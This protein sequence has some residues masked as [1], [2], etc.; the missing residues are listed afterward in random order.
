MVAAAA[1]PEASRDYL[2]CSTVAV[3]VIIKSQ[4]LYCVWIE[5]VL[6]AEV[7]LTQKANLH[8]RSGGLIRVSYKQPRPGS[9]TYM[10]QDCT[11]WITIYTKASPIESVHKTYWNNTKFSSLQT[12]TRS[13]APP[14]VSVF[15]Q[16]PIPSLRTSFM[17]DPKLRCLPFFI[18]ELTIHILGQWL[19][20]L[21]SRLPA[22]V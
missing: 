3:W 19:Q 5:R 4:G 16:T 17:D 14:Q 13:F 12:S 1:Y 9:Q 22:I 8:T 20:H 7:H 21:D 2:T 18:G 6:Q 11:T 10:A 15:D